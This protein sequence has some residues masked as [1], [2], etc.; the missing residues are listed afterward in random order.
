MAAA[1]DGPIRLCRDLLLSR[2]D[3]FVGTVTE[4]LLIYALGRGLEYY[5]MP[6]IRRDRARGRA[7]D[8]YRWSVDH[9]RPREESL[10]SRCGGTQ[11]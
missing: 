3:D 11:S 5:D 8:D 7:A 4:K 2:P 9:P 10:R 6:T 1:F